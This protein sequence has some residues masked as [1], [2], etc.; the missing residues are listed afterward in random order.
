MMELNQFRQSAFCLKVRMALA[1]KSLNYRVIEITPGIGQVA[2]FRLSGQRQLPVLIDGNH[3]IAD[4]S[5]IIR[6]LEKICPDPKLLPNDPQEAAMAHLIE[7]WADTTMAKAARNTLIKAAVKDK[8]LLKALLPEEI[9]IKLRD[10]ASNLPTKIFKKLP[11][12]LN[13]KETSNLLSSLKHLSKFVECNNW[14]VGKEMTIADISVAAQLSLLKFPNSAGK[15]LIGKGCPGFKDNIELINLFEWRDRLE[16][17]LM[18]SDCE[19]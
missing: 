18:K 1:A 2:I 16:V 3:V 7:D 14:L 11:N 9:P 12:L 4:S 17:N 5:E 15:E 19:D 6:Y 8:T 10:L 13:H